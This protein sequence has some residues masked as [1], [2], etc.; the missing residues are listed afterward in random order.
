MEYIENEG[1]LFRG[2]SRS[3]PKEVWNPD[4]R[5]FEP[6]AGVTPKPIEWGDEISAAEAIN[7]MMG[8]MPTRS[9]ESFARRRSGGFR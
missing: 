8:A 9:A 1:A 5:K 4:T 6:Y 7:M 2:P 3:F